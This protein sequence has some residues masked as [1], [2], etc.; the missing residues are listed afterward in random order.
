[1][2]LVLALLLFKKY[3]TSKHFKT[4]QGKVRIH[5]AEGKTI[6]T[7]KQNITKHR[8]INLR[9]Q[10]VPTLTKNLAVMVL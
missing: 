9:Y 7:Y 8:Y 1:M 10:I 5:G 6:Y 3:S 4:F 2:V